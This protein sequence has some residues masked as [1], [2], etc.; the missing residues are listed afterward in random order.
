MKGKTAYVFPGQGSQSVGM[1]K[2]IYETS[3]VAKAVF[4]E[5]D[6]ALGFPISELCFNGPDSELQQTVNS[7][8][9]IMTVSMA[10]LKAALA[11][12]GQG[13][14]SPDFVAGHSLGEY[15]ALLAADVFNFADAVRLVW[16]RGRL[17]HEA[18]MIRP[19]GM[20][21][22]IGLDE[23]CVA[24]ICF[25]SGV[26]IANINS[27]AQIVVSGP[28]A[29]LIKAVELARQKGARH[30]IEL[31]VSGAFHSSLMEPVVEG[32]TKVI[33]RVKF[34]NPT[35]PVV[36]NSSG[37]MVSTAEE[38]KAE[39]IWQLCNSVQWNRSIEFMI[40]SGVSTFIEIGPGRVLSGLIR[41]I[42]SDVKVLHIDN[43]K[44]LNSGVHESS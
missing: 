26:E 28:K 32:M 19:G 12:A 2:D 34:N 10:S 25:D 8:P 4:D 7:Q 39:L 42:N 15:C 44:S 35:I 41:R 38:I 22:I 24:G 33:S 21:A 30:A 1:G 13:G 11:A 14:L 6:S 18:G 36:V 43:I 3:S 20:A 16:E 29:A 37:K 23:A 9:A 17:M 27:P 31:K 40:E 5:A